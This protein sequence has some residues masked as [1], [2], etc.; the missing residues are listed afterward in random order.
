MA[1]EIEYKFLLD[2]VPTII[3]GAI[4]EHIEQGYLSYG[5]ATVRVR[6]SSLNGDLDSTAAYITIKGKQTGLTRK[7]FEYQI[8]EEDARQ[9]L[10]MCKSTI[11]KIRYAIYHDTRVIELDVF[12]ECFEGLVMAEIEVES[13]DVKV[14]LPDYFGKAIDVSKDMD[15]TN[16][17]IA[18]YGI[19][20]R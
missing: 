12:Q 15:Y 9:M 1:D 3:P 2:E 5:D 6:I 4:C 10:K 20:K 14:T 19:P 18:K 13:E 8:P 16:A 7:E 17:S 11:K